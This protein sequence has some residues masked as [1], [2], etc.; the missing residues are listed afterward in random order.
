MREEGEGEAS[1]GAGKKSQEKG[2]EDRN[3]RVLTTTHLSPY[4]SAG[5]EVEETGGKLSLG[6]WGWKIFL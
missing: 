3:C 4:C 6:E 2:E 1:T 5:G